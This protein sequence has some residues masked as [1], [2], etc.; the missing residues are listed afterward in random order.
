[1]LTGGIAHDFNNLL[2]GITGFAELALDESTSPTID[3]KLTQILVA[4][5]KAAELTDQMLTYSGNNQVRRTD[6]RLD[7]VVEDILELMS[8]VISKK[9]TLQFQTTEPTLWLKADA[10]QLNQVM[11]NLVTNASDALN[12]EGGSIAI[13]SGQTNLSDEDLNKLYFGANLLPGKYAFLSVT[14]T[15]EGM[16][17]STQEKLFDPFFST[18]YPGRGLGMASVAGILQNHYGAA[19]IDSKL[20]R[21]TTIKIYLPLT[22]VRE[23]H[24]ENEVTPKL[25]FRNATVLIIEDDADVRMISKA[26]LTEA[27][28]KVLLAS[29]GLE[30]MDL[31]HAKHKKIDLVLL[32]CSLPYLSGAEIY[33]EMRTIAPELPVLFYSG[34]KRDTAIPEL[35]GQMNINFIQK[36][37]KA[38]DLVKR[39]NEVLF[40]RETEI[41][42]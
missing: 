1:V 15:G 26:I 22:E 18:K 14:D 27:G 20:N 4:A 11:M 40:R 16:S 10:T 12:D 2:M 13:E 32:D 25:E 30:G 23:H 42:L 19:H 3:K 5:G 36:P 6:I 17:Q 33:Q 38:E 9:A 7:S 37:I 35:A 39:V 31:F 29:E 34:F 24:G 41:L 28:F 8:A 21:G